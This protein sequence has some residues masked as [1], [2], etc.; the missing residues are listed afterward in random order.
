MTLAQLF[1]RIV[2]YVKPYRLLLVA[3]LS[4]TLLGSLLAQGESDGM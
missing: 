1:R 3:T 2:P 4:L